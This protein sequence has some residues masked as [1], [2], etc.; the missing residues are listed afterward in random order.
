MYRSAR[1][2]FLVTWQ[3]L[4][5]FCSGVVCE[6]QLCWWLD[7]VLSLMYFL[8]FLLG[9]VWFSCF[10]FVVAADDFFCSF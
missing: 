9:E 7:V 10:V 8:C 5:Q 3:M 2:W 1:C 4:L 6:K